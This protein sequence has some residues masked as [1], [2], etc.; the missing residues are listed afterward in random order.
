MLLIKNWIVLILLDF[1]ELKYYYLLLKW[2]IIFWL[3]LEDF[4]SISNYKIKTRK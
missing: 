4:I 2:Y 3:F 1:V